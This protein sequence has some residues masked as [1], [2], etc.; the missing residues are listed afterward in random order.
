M[1]QPRLANLGPY[2]FQR[3][4]ALLR[5]CEPAAGMDA[6]DAGVGEP[7]QPLPA[8]AR[9]ILTDESDG[10]TRYPTTRGGL[11]LRQAIAGWLCR[12]YGLPGVDAQTQVL[13]ANGTREALFAVAHALIDPR[14]AEKL[15]VAM[16]NPM[17]QIY[18]GAAITAGA[19]P[20]FLD[21]R[22]DHGFR[23]DLTGVADEIWRRMAMVYV[24]SPGNPTGWVAHRDDYARLLELADRHDFVICAD[25]CYSEIYGDQPPAGLLEVA[26]ALGQRDF[27]RCLV[28]N[29]LSKRSGMPG[30]RSGFV[31]GD[32]ALIEQ[33]AQWRTYTGPA[34]PPPL[35]AVATAAWNDEAHVEA[36]RRVYRQSIE[37]FFEA[38]G[39]DA[40][41]PQGSFF[42]WLPVA[43]DEAFARAAFEQQA[44][45]VLPGRYLG[46]DSGDG[47]NPGGAYVRLALVDG[48][49]SA[50]ELAHRLRAVRLS[51]CS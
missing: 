21:C 17:Y 44:V 43:D 35:Q 22:A 28:F 10:L 14:A 29:S 39:G 42:V 16:P 40:V 25:E 46:A 50:A 23:P 4:A 36:G 41:R 49:K 51:S 33:F 12:R 6:I 34:T 27:A 48:P 24:C 45:K 37:A 9:K 20:C 31:A 18:L 3:L 30:L 15:I 26:Q 7:R 1:H 47:S 11:A 8:F 19:E 5:G 32:A 13:A 38:Y 2:P